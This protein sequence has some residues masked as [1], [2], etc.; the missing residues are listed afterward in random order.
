[1]RLVTRKELLEL[2][3]T[4]YGEVPVDGYSFPT[5]LNI[6]YGS[7]GKEFGCFTEE[8]F[9]I[10]YPDIESCLDYYSTVDYVFSN[11]DKEFT[12]SD[13]ETYRNDSNLDID[14]KYFVY[15]DEDIRLMIDKL[16]YL[17]NNKET[18]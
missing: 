14:K 18:E 5:S 8:Q 12:I 6:K 3:N 13:L 1:M 9:P 2:G 15:S 17:L 16:Q 10:T 4:L 7:R 11:P